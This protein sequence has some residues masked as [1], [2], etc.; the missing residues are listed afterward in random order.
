[1]PL[2]IMILPPAPSDAALWPCPSV[3]FSHVQPDDGQHDNR[4]KRRDEAVK[5]QAF[6]T[7]AGHEKQERHADA[8]GAEAAVCHGK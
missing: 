6:H 8:E 7:G 4:R 2:P 1:M 5:S 3:P